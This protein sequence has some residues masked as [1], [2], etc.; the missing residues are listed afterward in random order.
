MM[1]RIHS[2]RFAMLLFAIAGGQAFLAAAPQK[3]FPTPEAAVQ[4]LIAAVKSNS[5]DEMSAVLGDDMKDQFRT[6]DASLSD[7][8]RALFLQSAEAVAKFESDGSPDKLTLYVGE[9]A[10]PFPSPLVKEGST[11]RFDGKEGKQEILD[12]RIGRNEM[13]AVETCLGYVEA[14]L[15]YIREDHNGDGM[16]E[17]AHRLVSTPGKQDGLYWDSGEGGPA[18]PLGPAFVRASTGDSPA[19]PTVRHHGYH[20]H[21]LTAQGSN[22]AGGVRNYLIDGRL[23]GGFGLIAW[24]TEYGVTGIQTYIVNQ[25]G[26]VYEKDLGSQTATAAAAIQSFDPDAS[27]K[28]MR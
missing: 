6:G 16:L 4:A 1:T 14:Q 23:L 11:W 28:K 17:F 15:D 7:L 18:S 22:A 19:R 9:Q 10:W 8:D 20:F 12:R 27:W 26:V 25:T 21:I 13:H 2:N 5:M 3:T 24:P